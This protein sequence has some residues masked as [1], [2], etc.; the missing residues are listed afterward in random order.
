MAIRKMYCVIMLD[1]SKIQASDLYYKF[2]FPKDRPEI[3]FLSKEDALH[4]AE[5]MVIHNPKIPVVLME[6]CDLFE[7]KRPEIIRKVFQENGDLVPK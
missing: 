5:E 2:S 3:F 7:A 4:F 6:S 1:P